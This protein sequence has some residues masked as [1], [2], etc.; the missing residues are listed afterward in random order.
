LIFNDNDNY[1]VVFNEDARELDKPYL[2]INKATGFVDFAAS[3]LPQALVISEQFNQI[4][5]S[6]DYKTMYNENE[7]LFV[8]DTDGEDQG[9][10]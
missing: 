6:E 7:F 3:N 9:F 8:D 2:V 5:T 4:I 10:H 1:K